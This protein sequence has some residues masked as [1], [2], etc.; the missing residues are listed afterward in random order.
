M[1]SETKDSSSMSLSSILQR[2]QSSLDGVLAQQIDAVMLQEIEDEEDEELM[3]D[4]IPDENETDEN[5]DDEFVE[6]DFVNHQDNTIN[7]SNEFS[8]ALAFESGLQHMRE[9]KR[10]HGAHAN[11]NRYQ[12]TH[13]STSTSSNTNA[14]SN[15]QPLE[16]SDH[17]QMNNPYHH[18][19]FVLKCQFSALI[20]AFDPRP[21]KNNINQIQDISVPQVLSNLPTKSFEASPFGDNL[22]KNVD[23]KQKQ[24]KV[25]LYL[26]VQ[27]HNSAFNQ[28]ETNLEFIKSEIKLTNKNATI[29]QYVQN[30]IELNP[31][32]ESPNTLHYEKMKT[33]WDMNY[34]LIYRESPNTNEN[35]FNES[36]SEN[37][38]EMFSSNNNQF[39]DVYS[40]NVVQV[41]K[42]L[43]ILRKLIQDSRDEKMLPLVNSDLNETK[44]GFISEKINN[45]L[46]QQLQDPLVL[47]S[48]SLPD[49]CRGLLHSYKFLFPFE[50]RQLY[51]TTTAFGVSRSIVWLQNKRDTLLSTLRG[52][53]SQRV[54]R[55][56]HEFRIGRLK[57]ERIKIP[58]EPTSNLLKS[59]MNTL[60]FHAT[61]KAILEIEFVEEEGT[62]LGPTLEFFSLIAGELQ[63]K[64]FALWHCTDS[65][66]VNELSQ[67]E[68]ENINESYV[69]QLNGLFPAAYPPIEKMSDNK[70]YCLHY[71]NVIE[72]FNFIGIFLAKSLQDQRLVDI[73][74]SFPFLKLIS[75]FREQSSGSIKKETCELNNKFDLDGILNL[76]D[77]TLI[78]PHR[79]SLLKQLQNLII[80]RKSNK[81]EEFLVELNDTKFK[82]DDLG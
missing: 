18:D 30:L 3:R 67:E 64:K 20:P 10:R 9:L 74:F 32:D 42:L 6:E 38:E 55:D 44:K 56:D 51:F 2:C 76:E 82:L 5:L 25:D 13:D 45:K 68:L 46:I 27:V 4:T 8:S 80:S 34:S 1:S 66:Q 54:M 41:L 17:F 31:K 52:P 70:K 59:A 60:K 35:D 11:Q 23:I 28:F 37:K 49:W 33:V 29:F 19:E 12:I 40:C 14:N 81:N 53:L 36:L 16:A 63:R 77:L 58:R 79:A 48:R 15:G 7:N 22:E 21:G 78:D 24:P 50:T 43:T 75:G 73:P 65:E 47:A 61:R 57:H 69:H 62:G 39:V 26:R 72:Y 71:Q